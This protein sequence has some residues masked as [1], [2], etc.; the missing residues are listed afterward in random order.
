MIAKE[1][2]FQKNPTKFEEIKGLLFLRIFKLEQ[3]K[4]QNIRGF[5]RISDSIFSRGKRTVFR[6][7]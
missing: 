6:K 3:R 2:K 7:A 4:L 1:E 5:H